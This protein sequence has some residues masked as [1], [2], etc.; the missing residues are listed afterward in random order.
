MLDLVF[1]MAGALVVS[2]FGTRWLRG[3]V[4]SYAAWFDHRLG[5]DRPEQAEEE[6]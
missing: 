4:E 5:T 1:D 3:M 2:L 6:R